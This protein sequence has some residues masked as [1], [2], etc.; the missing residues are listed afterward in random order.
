[1]PAG[2]GSVTPSWVSATAP[3]LDT[4]TVTVA[5]PPEATWTG[6]NDLL[7]LRAE[8]KVMEALPATGSTARVVPLASVSVPPAATVLG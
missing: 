3:E 1:M 4:R 8:A 5:L 6:L 7:A 2:S